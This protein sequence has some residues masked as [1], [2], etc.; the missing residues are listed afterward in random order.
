MREAREAES[1]ADDLVE[2]EEVASRTVHVSRSSSESPAR[3]G[4]SAMR[5]ELTRVHSRTTK[6]LRMCEGRVFR[7]R[8]CLPA[9]NLQNLCLHIYRY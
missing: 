9:K 4:G 8:A 7:S 6:S 2:G 3:S 1:D 5:N